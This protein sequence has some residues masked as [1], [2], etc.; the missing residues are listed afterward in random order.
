MNI[1]KSNEDKIILFETENKYIKVGE[2]LFSFETNDRILRYF[3]KEGFNDVIYAYVC[4]E[5]DIYFMIYRKYITIQEYKNSTQKDEYQYLYEK[6]DEL[7]A[8]HITVENEGIVK[9]GN[10]FLNCKISGQ[11]FYIINFENVSQSF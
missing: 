7:K 9:H 5:E 10:D 4:G 2:N 11:R 1:F 3:S 6:D 8:D